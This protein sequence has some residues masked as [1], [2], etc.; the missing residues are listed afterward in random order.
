MSG[1]DALWS[2]WCGSKP[3]QREL[4]SWMQAVTKAFPSE[5]IDRE[6]SPVVIDA[7]SPHRI[8][9]DRVC[10]YGLSFNP[11]KSS[12]P[13]HQRLSFVF[14]QSDLHFIGGPLVQAWAPGHWNSLFEHRPLP[15]EV[16]AKWTIS[17]GCQ[18]HTRFFY[19][20]W[21]GIFLAWIRFFVMPNL[22]YLNI[23]DHEKG[24]YDGEYGGYDFLKPIF[25]RRVERMGR[26]QAAQ[27]FGAWL[28]GELEKINSKLERLS[29]DFHS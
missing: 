13:V 20:R 29:S 4:I 12:D 24:P 25:E 28:A 11:F 15:D 8:E 19:E 21:T 14:L 23:M 27:T 10:I 26:L 17:L 9:I 16:N 2:G 7:H 6:C 18:V 5:F 22:V 3:E 1:G